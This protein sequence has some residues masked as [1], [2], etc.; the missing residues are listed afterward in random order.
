MVA[1]FHFLGLVRYLCIISVHMLYK[2]R[3]LHSYN[4]SYRPSPGFQITA[5]LFLFQSY[6]S[7][8][9][10]IEHIGKTNVF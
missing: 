4:G 10:K 1:T 8:L 2:H 7:V 9:S 3:E 6:V 5:P